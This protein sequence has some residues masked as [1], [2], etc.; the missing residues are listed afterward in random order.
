MNKIVFDSV[1][2]KNFLTFGAKKQT[3]IFKKGINVILGLDVDS[4]RSN[5]SGKSSLLETIPFVLFGKTARAINKSNF[6]NWKN[7]KNCEVSIDFHRGDD[8]YTI[9]RAIKPDKLE[10]YLN[11][12]LIPIPSNVKDYQEKIKEILGFD[13]QTFNS[14]FHT[15]IN[16][17][18]PILKMSV[19]QKRAFLENVFMLSMYSDL[20][21][22]TN[23]KLREITKNIDT[24][25]MKNQFNNK[26]I[27]EY[28]QQIQDLKYKLTEFP[29]NT[30]EIN[31][32]K[33]KI[34]EFKDPKPEID[35]I[36]QKLEETK[37]KVN[38][39]TT[40]EL[41]ISNNIV[42]L[43][44]EILILKKQYDSYG[45]IEN[46]ILK[47]NK[48]R[49]DIKNITIIDD[50][51]ENEITDLLQ[52]K[53]EIASEITNLKIK[54]QSIK[55]DINNI[56][57]QLEL[58]SGDKCP[59][60]QSDL[61]DNE[62]L[63]KLQND[64]DRLLNKLQSVNSALTS[65]EKRHSEYI[66]EINHKQH[67]LNKKKEIDSKIYEIQKQIDILTLSENRIDEFRSVKNNINTREEQ[68]K[69]LIEKQKSLQSNI[70][71]YNNIINNY[72][73]RL[74][75]LNTVINTLNEY[76]KKLIKLENIDNSKIRKEI[77]ILIDENVKKIGICQK[78]IDEN[79]KKLT[80]LRELLDYLQY[81]K[82]LCQD[83]GVKQYAISNMMG[84]ITSRTNYYLSE[85]GCNFYVKFT[86]WLDDEIIGNGISKCVYEN[87]S[88]GE[89]RS[90]DIALQLAFID[91]TKMRTG[92]NLDLMVFDEI[93][94]SSVDHV[95]INS[96]MKILT[97]LQ[98]EID[99]KI[100]LITHRSEISDADNLYLIE[101]KEGF[102]T[103]REM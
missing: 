42:K 12:K 45:D 17:I 23:E 29:D 15:N 87:L 19:P 6:V 78:D 11:D 82:E 46:D 81:V 47:L 30:D 77:T 94:D 60:C 2:F 86:K 38:E 93:L 3:I 35:E 84:Y 63:Y 71:N 92:I 73:K 5:G 95:G 10:I 67:R 100:F 8:R 64:Y 33:R 80:K 83:D 52:K 68:L 59:V 37:S 58:L 39:L 31:E 34:A 26:S 69:I 27:S 62:L 50:V 96:M 89:K 18:T 70:K 85:S 21:D 97:T 54:E 4:G 55:S 79:D 43:N 51:D 74:N 72:N 24:L 13:F 101:K 90:V 99:G 32:I 44:D 40:S 102:S 61:K 53:D 20:I 56:S 1:S 7:K 16:S 28:R 9:L 57:N 48:L 25:L 22:S 41:I 88:S 98:K 75:E 65:L 14:L 66:S 49:N 103:V 36:T 76:Q 91:V